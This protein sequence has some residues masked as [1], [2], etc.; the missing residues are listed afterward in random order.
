ML[1][2]CNGQRLIFRVRLCCRGFDSE[3]RPCGI[4]TQ[5]PMGAR[6][7]ELL[8]SAGV[9]GVVQWGRQVQSQFKG[10]SQDNGI[11]EGVIHLE[12]GCSEIQGPSDVLCIR[13][14]PSTVGRVSVDSRLR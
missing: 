13:L 10:P 1:S 11:E 12:F 4:S 3:I 14:G 8:L 9:S 6:K 2:S 5:C 7:L